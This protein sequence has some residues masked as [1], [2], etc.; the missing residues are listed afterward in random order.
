M[1]TA[2]SVFLPYSFKNVMSFF[3][4]HLVTCITHVTKLITG[5]AFILEGWNKGFFFSLCLFSELRG[6]HDQREKG[7]EEARVD[8]KRVG[9]RDI[10]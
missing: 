4:Y 3:F 1:S 6:E 8:K 9:R 2:D 5:S 10:Q 7:G